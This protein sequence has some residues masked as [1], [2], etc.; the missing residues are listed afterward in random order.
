MSSARSHLL[1]L[2]ALLAGQGCGETAGQGP[3]FQ[4]SAA[5]AGLVFQH[6]T[7]HEPQRY[8]MPEIMGGGVALAD[9]N[10]DGK[11][12]VYFVQSAAQEP[13]TL[14]GGANRLYLNTSDAHGLRFED[15]GPYSGAADA[16]YGMGVTAGDFDADGDIDLYV[17]NWGRNVLLAN[18]GEGRF[19]DVTLEAG[20][21]HTGWGTS[22]VFL[23]YDGDGLLDLYVTNYIDWTVEGEITCHDKL[24]LRDYCNP[25]NYKSPAFDVLYHNEGGGRFNDVSLASGVASAPGTGL[26]VACADFDGDGH[27]DIFVANDLMPDFLWRNLGDGTFVDIAPRAGCAVDEYGVSKAGMGVAIADVNDDGDP[28]L[29]VGNISGQSDSFFINRGGSFEDRTYI[30]GLGA[31]SRPFTRFGLGWVDFNCDGLLD[32]YQTNGR[33]NMQGHEWSGD[34]YAEPDVLMQGGPGLRFTEVPASD[35][36][37]QP[38]V[39]SG[40]GA[41]FGD[42]DDDGGIDVVVVNRDG[43]AFLLHNVI[44]QRGSWVGFHLVDERGRGL[45]HATLSCTV[46]ER[47]ITRTSRTAS[48]YCSANDPRILIGLGS[49]R[50]AERVEVRWPDGTRESFGGRGAGAYHE[51]RRGAGS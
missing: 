25:D 27:L 3:W 21:G 7:G 49:V 47:R 23:D 10:G 45:T 13:G 38:R 46:G 5:D 42:L 48:S 43:P 51:L 35:V 41:A 16:G 39:A 11:L 29:L 19:R 50:L 15:A 34:P 40:R 24:G 18:E 28:D 14:R 36:L 37:R 30:A 20:V 17:T 26:G 31:V 4:E 9:V 32:L 12:D 22:A 1:L 2:A 6:R 8:L 44:A 33:V